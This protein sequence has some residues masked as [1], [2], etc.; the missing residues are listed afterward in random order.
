MPEVLGWESIALNGSIAN[1]QDFKLRLVPQGLRLPPRPMP[2]WAR[3]RW[4]NMPALSP[5]STA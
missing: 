1:G 4:W 2:R 3:H 5:G